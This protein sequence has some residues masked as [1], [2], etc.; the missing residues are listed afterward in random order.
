MKKI[1][2]DCMHHGIC[3]HYY[4]HDKQ[5]RLKT[6]CCKCST[7]AVQ[8][9]RDKLKEMAVVHLGGKCIECGYCKSIAALEFHHKDPNEKD[10]G[11]SAKGYTRSWERVKKELEKCVLLCANCHREIH[12]GERLPSW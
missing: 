10:F 2:K 12:A 1:V 6:K 3:E 7:T 8:K 4:Y 11:I 9:R 5:F